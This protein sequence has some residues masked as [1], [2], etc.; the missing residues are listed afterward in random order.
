MAVD[1]S[2]AST[3]DSMPPEVTIEPAD[4]GFMVRHYRRSGKKDEGGR[5]IRQVA[6]TADEALGHARRVLGGGKTG[7]NKINMGGKGGP[8][9]SKSR[10]HRGRR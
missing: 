9:R 2:T 6:A 10:R 1:L 7:S 4:N 8:T 5:T 3:S